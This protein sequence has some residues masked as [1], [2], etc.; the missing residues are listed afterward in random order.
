M[1]SYMHVAIIGGGGLI[2]S[3]TAARLAACGARAPVFPA[4][5]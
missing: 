1:A 5:A 4:I 3:A 2:G